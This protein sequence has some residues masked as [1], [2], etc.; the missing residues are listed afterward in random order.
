MMLLALA[1]SFSA[2]TALSLSMEKHQHDLHG[3]AA[4]APA[5]R[6]QWRVLGWALLAAAFALCVADQGW[7][8]GPVL[9]L[10]AMT[11]AGVTL[12]LGLYPYRPTW[13]APLAIAL[14]VLGLVLELL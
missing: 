7:A 9:W 14:P 13:I 8:M 11:L 12:S 2:F 1:L 5:R 4:A 6:M 10:G 3:K